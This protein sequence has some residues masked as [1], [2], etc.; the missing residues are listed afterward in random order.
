MK[1]LVLQLKRIGDLVLTTPALLALRHQ[2]PQAHITLVVA[3]GCA[4]LLPAIRGIDHASHSSQPWTWLHTLPGRW[5]LCLDFTGSDRSALL[6][7]LSRARE[8]R[9][10]ASVQRRRWKAVAYNRWVEADVR[11]EHTIDHCLKLVGDPAGAREPSLSIPVTAES[12]AGQ[13]LLEH[14]IAGPFVLI[15][16]GTARMEKYWETDR[17]AEVIAHLQATHGL[18]CVLTGGSHPYELAHAAAIRA[19]AP[20]VTDLAGKCSLLGLSAVIARARLVLSCDTATVHLAAAFQRPQIALFGPTNPAHWRPRHP[21]AV[22][23]SATHPDKPLETFNP[24]M[25]GAPMHRLSTAAVIRAT[26]GLLA[27]STPL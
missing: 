20:G 5:D 3:P 25:P 13:L 4:G 21:A 7:G 8:R 23:L 10:F 24:R 12:A 19:A 6:C 9:T 15:H 17:W 2:H 18:R 27:R 14:G 26:E 22:V 16:P 1:V 11:A